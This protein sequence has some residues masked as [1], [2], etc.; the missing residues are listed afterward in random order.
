MLFS[1]FQGS[2]YYFEDELDALDALSQSESSR[3]VS[4]VAILLREQWAPQ[5]AE[6]G[7]P[8]FARLA[9]MLQRSLGAVFSAVGLEGIGK[10]PTINVLRFQ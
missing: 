3:L 10:A 7:S 4:R 1:F 2:G 5:L 8:Q 6:Q 9:L